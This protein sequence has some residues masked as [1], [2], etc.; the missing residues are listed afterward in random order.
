MNLSFIKRL[1]SLSFAAILLV[2]CVGIGIEQSGSTL[3]AVEVIEQTDNTS[4]LADSQWRLQEIQMADGSVST[5]DAEADYTLMLTASGQMAGQ[6]DCNTINSTYTVDGSQ[7]SF[8]PIA[9]TKALCPP[10]SLSDTYIQALTNTNAYALEGETLT[11]S[12]GSDGNTLIFATSAASELT[13]MGEAAI[14]AELLGAWQWQ[15]FEDS[16]SGA[17]SN[18]ITVDDPSLYVLTLLDDGA[19][20]I[21][22]DCNVAQMEYSVDGSS[23]TF[24]PGPMTLAA[25]GPD[26]LSNEFVMRLGEVAGYTLD[27]EHLVLNLQADAGNLIFA[28]A[29]DDEAAADSSQEAVG[30]YK[31]IFPA[32]SSPGIDST[33]YL[34]TDKS[35]RLVSDYLNEE[36]PIV[37]V[38]SWQGAGAEGT[39]IFT[40]QE[41]REYDTPQ[42][43]TFQLDGNALT[44]VYDSAGSG[45][46]V[47][48]Y[49]RFE[50]LATGEQ[51][52]PYDAASMA[53]VDDLTGIYKGFAPA[54]SCCGLDL[55]LTLGSDG[56]ATLKSDYLNGDAPFVE[57]GRWTVTDNIL[58]VALDGA[59]SPWT[60]AISEEPLTLISNE[61]TIFGEAPLRLYSLPG[62]A[63]SMNSS[64]E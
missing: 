15:A 11:L 1:L 54:A 43:V 51:A 35:A 19:A 17:Q 32:A 42:T 26:S 4:A 13:D 49:L 56:S 59:D 52:V 22:A 55:T 30:I 62:I 40:G 36:S 3:P 6:A 34:N 7:L 64:A 20:Q 5:P 61:I 58:E 38:G 24:M 33:L 12:F 29:A 63:L 2:G 9:S 53:G 39:V 57:Q 60:Y 44:L 16:A 47:Q 41:D 23:L 10:G 25:C 46:S 8:G 37:E 14:P 31:G 18:D 27:G 21:T 28:P 48:H 45:T 50:A